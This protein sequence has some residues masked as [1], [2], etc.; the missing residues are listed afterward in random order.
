MHIGTRQAI[1]ALAEELRQQYQG[2]LYGDT[3]NGGTSTLYISQVPFEAIDQALV[4]NA[5]QAEQPQPPMRMHAAK[6]VLEEQVNWTR[7]ALAAPVVGAIAAFAGVATGKQKTAQH[8]HSHDAHSHDAH[9]HDDDSYDESAQR[10]SAQRE[11]SPQ[12]ETTDEE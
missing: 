2:Y 7:L 9:S 12:E 10:E 4:A 8:A 5:A 11:S 1:T 3:Q 6:N